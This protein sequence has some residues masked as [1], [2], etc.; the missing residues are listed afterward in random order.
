MTDDDKPTPNPERFRHALGSGDVVI[1]LGEPSRIGD[2]ADA[3]SMR[4][5]F[6]QR[7]RQ[8]REESERQKG[9]ESTPSLAAADGPYRWV[10]TLDVE[11]GGAF[12]PSEYVSATDLGERLNNDPEVDRVREIISSGKV[13]AVTLFVRS[14]AAVVAP[15]VAALSLARVLAGMGHPLAFVRSCLVS[16]DEEEEFDG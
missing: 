7:Q 9:D 4:E 10:V 6:D 3:L 15:S 12:S 2:I 5:W 16:L 13:L 8:L 11:V 1:P 14:A